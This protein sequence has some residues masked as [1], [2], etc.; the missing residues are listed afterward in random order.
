MKKM[1]IIYVLLFLL[2][3]IL[4]NPTIVSAS[5]KECELNSEVK[6]EVRI[7]TDGPLKV[8]LNFYI[9]LKGIEELSA[10]CEM[11][12]SPTHE[13][14][15][16]SDI[17]GNSQLIDE[18]YY[19]V[20]TCTSKSPKYGGTYFIEVDPDSNEGVEVNEEGVYLTF[21]PCPNQE[22]A[23]EKMSLF[24][25]FRQLNTFDLNSFSFMFYA[26]TTQTINSDATIKFYFNFLNEIGSVL[27]SPVEADC[28][29]EE[30]VTEIDESIGIAPASFKCLFNEE[31]VTDE[32]SS[33]QITSSEG[34]AGLPINN[35]T[36]LNPKLVDDAINE[37]LLTNPANQ[38]GNPPSIISPVDNLVTYNEDQ[39]VFTMVFE[40]TQG[41]VNAEVGQTFEFPLTYPGGIYLQG[42]I[43]KCEDAAV[44]VR[45]G[46]EGEI[47]TAPL[48]WE[49]TAISINGQES[50][51]LPAYKT[52]SI[53]TKGYSGHYEEEEQNSDNGQIIID[54]GGNT[55]E[56]GRAHV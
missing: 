14:L 48:I 32:V 55:Q 40:F 36:L 5:F 19:Y 54:D 17:S 12:N 53:T 7:G 51:V 43:T 23:E 46:I 35:S 22:T 1:L 56:I 8:P 49:Q 25:S 6:I 33:L 3:N 24:L 30:P 44:T 38:G 20:V 4:A 47:N 26:L 39:G 37:G 45:F 9:N 27:P 50:F 15:E 52:N 11:E 31:Y 13:P 34:V 42:N 28:T 21:S 10:F 41:N 2:E 16:G 18:P 29:I